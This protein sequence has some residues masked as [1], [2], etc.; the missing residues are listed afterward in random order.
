[1]NK[2][3]SNSFW[4]MVEQTVRMLASVLIGIY[5]ARYLG[6][7]D[8]GILSYAMAIT[9]FI[10][11]I[12]RMGMD[13]ILVRE[14][15]KN[16]GKELSFMGTAFWLMFS[17]SLILYI[18]VLLYC[19]ISDDSWDLKIYLLI[20][21]AGG[22]FS[23]FLIIDYFYQSRL[24]SKYPA[25]TKTIAI[26][27]V[28]IFKLTLILTKADLM[29]FVIAAFLDHFVLAV[30]LTSVFLKK[31]KQLFFCYFS[32]HHAKQM[33]QSAF[34]MILSAVA[35]LIYMRI[36]QI[37]IKSMLDVEQVGIYTA[38]IK[39]YE[40]WIAFPY[41]LTMSLLPALTA[42][43][44]DDPTGQ[45]YLLRFK[46]LFSAIFWISIV[47]ALFVT[48]IS[49]KLISLTFGIEY[50]ESVN[51]VNITMWT[52]VFTAIGSVS[53]RY[54]NVE[55]M[56]KKIATRTFMAAILNIILNFFLIPQYGIE[57]AAISTLICTIF[58]NYLMDWLDGDLKTLLKLKHQSIITNPFKAR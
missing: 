15:V 2:Y 23:T 33:L 53:A 29:W 10:M 56:E 25:I 3:T 58:S 40:A 47:V 8:F 49:K 26:T 11:A 43:K 37:M 35:V 55:K 32:I 45:R 24:Q 22:L 31:Q 4:M 51:I 20:I 27:L 28:S 52:A 9:A 36:D 46:Q 34:P 6:P 1:M 7:E 30:L 12:S 19:L 39:I 57:G 50:L 18:G 48:L 41:V 14:L 44:K 38:G 16:P 54:F 21:T 42:L 13:A 17:M 5:I